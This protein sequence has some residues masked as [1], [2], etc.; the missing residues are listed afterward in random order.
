M[1]KAKSPSKPEGEFGDHPVC[2]Q[3]QEELI[4]ERSAGNIGHSTKARD[5]REHQHRDSVN[6]S[7][8]PILD[9][10]ESFPSIF[11]LSLEP[12][13]QGPE[14]P[15]GASDGETEDGAQ[16]KKRAQVVQGRLGGGILKAL[17]EPRRLLSTKASFLFPSGHAHQ[18]ELPGPGI[19]PR[20][21]SSP[22]LEHLPNMEQGRSCDEILVQLAGVRAAVT[23]ASLK[24]LEG[25]LES[26]LGDAI[27]C[28]DK[29]AVSKSLAVGLARLVK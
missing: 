10:G 9:R 19:G 13:G 16:D 28:G 26:C 18:Q 1:L 4:C 5:H 25:H 23:Q 22:G 3:P 24:L 27:D 17:F 29:T 8:C 15:D 2:R 20:Q 21:G 14:E 6:G 12:E 11:H 7:G